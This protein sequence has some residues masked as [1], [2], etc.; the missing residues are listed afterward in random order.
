MINIDSVWKEFPDKTL[1]ENISLKLSEGMRIG[2]V[3]P[4]GAGK[5][6]LLKIILDIDSPDKG[7]VTVGKGVSI[8]YL[9]QEA[10]VF[11]SLTVA[12]NLDIAL[13]QAFSNPAHRRIRR[14]KLINVII[15]SY[16]FNID[17]LCKSPI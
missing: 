1:F 8:G 6:T 15:K 9:P 2:L 3:G 5:T 11:R 14:E 4:N 10:S 12:E 7:K 13:S 17:R 16:K